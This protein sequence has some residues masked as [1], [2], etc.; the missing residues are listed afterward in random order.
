MLPE[1]EENLLVDET[2]TEEALI[3][4]RTYRLNEDSLTVAG[5]IDDLDAIKQSLS[6]K[7]SGARMRF[8]ARITARS[9]RR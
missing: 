6:L 8:I 5:E 4:S 9:L 1:G 7:R 2:E 3:T